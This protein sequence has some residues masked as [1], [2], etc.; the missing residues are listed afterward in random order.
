VGRRSIGS[1]ENAFIL[2]QLVELISKMASADCTDGQETALRRKLVMLSGNR[3]PVYYN[4]A[5]GKALVIHP[6]D[7]P[8][9]LMGVEQGGATGPLTADRRAV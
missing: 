9:F 5:S 7:E 4:K 1:Q 3:I 6:R 2:T 8:P